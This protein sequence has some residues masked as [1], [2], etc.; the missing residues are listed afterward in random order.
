MRLNAQHR[1]P[2]WDYNNPEPVSQAVLLHQNTVC[3]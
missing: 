2:F 1:I 3:P